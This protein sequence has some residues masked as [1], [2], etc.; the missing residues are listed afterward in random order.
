MRKERGRRTEDG[1][2]RKMGKEGRWGRNGGGR[3]MME[4]EGRRGRRKERGIGRLL[5]D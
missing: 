2:R 5:E 4:K 1:D 3:R